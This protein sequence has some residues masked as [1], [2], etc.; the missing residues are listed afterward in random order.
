MAH[1]GTSIGP[2]ATARNPHFSVDW[3]GCWS[4]LPGGS[5]KHPR[6]GLGRGPLRGRDRRRQLIP[7]TR[8]TASSPGVDCDRRMERARGAEWKCEVAQGRGEGRKL[9]ERSR[10]GNGGLGPGDACVENGLDSWESRGH[11]G[12]SVRTNPRWR[13]PSPAPLVG[14]AL[15]RLSSGSC[16]LR[17]HLSVRFVTKLL[18]R[19]DGRAAAARLSEEWQRDTKDGTVISQIPYPYPITDHTGRP[20]PGAAGRDAHTVHA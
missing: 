17:C 20:A 11:R 14:A 15:G 4:C 1:A 5:A 3:D 8:R 12:L 19:T 16:G 18:R 2:T 13:E 10:K 6:C 9:E 7:E